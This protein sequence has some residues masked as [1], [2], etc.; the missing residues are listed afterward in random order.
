MKLYATAESERAAKG[1]GG[2]K[3]LKVSFTAETIAGRELLGTVELHV[4]DNTIHVQNNVPQKATYKAKDKKLQKAR[5][6]K[7]A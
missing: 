2:N 7:S 6:R 4:E 1:Q 3:R 5:T